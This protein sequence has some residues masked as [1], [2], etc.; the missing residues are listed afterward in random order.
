[1][2]RV[3]VEGNGTFEV[4]NG[5]RLVLALEEHG[6]DILHRCGGYARCT[7]CRVEFTAGEPDR[8]TVAERDKLAERELTGQV[9]LSCQIP[10]DHDMAV[11]VINRFS[12]SGLSDP[13]PPPER[14]MTPEPEWV[15][16]DEG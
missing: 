15:M 12:E 1:M 7:T 14:Q 16:K 10:V 9:R 13:G 2:P 6:I 4:E 5:T 3:E 11:R 8:M